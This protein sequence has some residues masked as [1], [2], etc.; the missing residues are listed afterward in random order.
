VAAECSKKGFQAVYADSPE[1]A[2]EKVLS[3][4]PQGTAVGISGSVS[5]REIGAIEALEK[6]GNPVVQ[7]WDP[8]LKT[9]E[10]KKARLLEE[11]SCTVHLTGTNAITQDGMLV[12]IDGTGNRT[13][14]MSWGPGKII[15][16][17]GI[18]KICPD[19]ETAIRRVRDVATP[20][21]ALRL[22]IDTPCAKTG[23]C[24]NCNSPQRV[25]R[26]LLIL[27]RATMGRESHVIIV[28]EPLGY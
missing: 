15:F 3:L 1:E 13:A 19:L 10:E 18:N 5:V 11:I 22:G 24:M 17:V 27:E 16:V 4:I 28:G 8:S 23:H 25:C 21:N 20:P 9:T 2:L 6:R 12:N 14:A 26:A 7:H